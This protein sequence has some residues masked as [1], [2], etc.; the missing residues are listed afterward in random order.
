MKRRREEDTCEASGEKVEE[1]NARVREK[2]KVENETGKGSENAR[3][4]KPAERGKR[5]V[6]KH[7]IGK[8]TQPRCKREYSKNNDNDMRLSRSQREYSWKRE[9]EKQGE[10]RRVKSWYVN[11]TEHGVKHK[12][13]EEHEEHEQ[14]NTNAKRKRDECNKQ[15]DG[16]KLWVEKGEEEHEHEAFGR[17]ALCTQ[18]DE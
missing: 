2:G 10:E 9:E 7:R 5:L 17:D 3:R 18:E 1:R 6:N 11:R 8:H 14:S 13:R 4:E 15:E 12:A 16:E